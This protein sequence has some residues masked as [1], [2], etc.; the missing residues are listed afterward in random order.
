MR[1]MLDDLELPLVQEVSTF[2]RRMLAELKPPGMDGSLLQNLGRR[3]TCILLWGVAA[4]PESRQFVEKLDRKHKAGDPLPFV[5]DITT[6]SAIEN[7]LIDDLRFQEVAGKT[8]RFA[9]VLTLRQ[10]QVPV[11][12]EVVSA[13]DTG[14][15]DE[16]LAQV[17]GLVEGLDAA[18][19]FAEG[20]S[21]FIPQLGGFLS[22]LEQ[23]RNTQ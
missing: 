5:A 16:A 17:Q 1:P 12:P 8:D 13:V 23:A 15:L 22:R 4:G 14:L 6:D 19:A 7:V 10:H 18:R 9:Y 21:R 2:D 20:L 11:E 3:P